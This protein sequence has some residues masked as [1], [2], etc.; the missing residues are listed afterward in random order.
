MKVLVVDMTHGG[1]VIASELS[2]MGFDVFAL[3]IY[4]TLKE[5]ARVSLVKKGVKMVQSSFLENLNERAVT[6]TD[7]DG[8]KGTC[9]ETY[10][11]SPESQEN[12]DLLL[13]LPVHCNFESEIKAAGNL[14]LKRMT[15]HEAVGFLLKNRINVP[16]IEV[17]GVKGKTSV[18]WMLKEI[19]KDLNPLVLSS[20]GVELIKDKKYQNDP[21]NGQIVE[22]E[23]Q[24]AIKTEETSG[25]SMKPSQK[26]D[27]ILKKNIS[28]TPAS[29]VEAFKLANDCETL[30]SCSMN[31]EVGIC[32]F[33]T[34]LGGT[35]LADVGVLTNVAENYPIAGGTRRASQAKAQIFKSK[36]VACNYKDFNSFYSK[37]GAS[38]NGDSVHSSHL[39]LDSDSVNLS[40]GLK[41]D[42][43]NS[44]YINLNKKTNTFG[45]EE[46]ANVR[47]SSIQFGLYRT[48][49]QLVVRNLK[50]IDGI[51]LNTSFEV[52]TFAPA[53][54]H[55]QNVL[56]VICASLTLGIPV[57]TIKQ[58]L[59]NFRGVE[60]RT[61]IGDREGS[62]VIA[63]VNPGLN[64][65][66]VKKAL[67]MVSNLERAGIVFGGKYGVTCEEIDEK[68]VS[69][70]LNDLNNSIPLV[71]V[72]E[73]G[74]NVKNNI[75]RDFKYLT[76]LKDAVDWAH[77]AGCKSILVVYRSNFSDLKLR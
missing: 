57:K 32:I 61:S 52:S 44:E 25:L 73:L 10:R 63:E 65:T 17:T 53:P 60:G 7:L 29:I 19:F 33:E 66:A 26:Q 12:Y 16:V 5:D 4:H 8:N 58:G 51:L 24:T 37:S 18:V 77:D 62:M 49:I 13:V 11:K 15:H 69:E 76:N 31:Q 21:E 48:T 36:M 30:Q 27:L 70:V 42:P 20:L 47:T 35:G 9:T 50:T 38:L 59:K 28:I 41:S 43:N 72:D 54:Y 55:V 71:L 14:K 46:D 40:P 39:K 56:A 6:E 1:T 34:S 75:K 45:F 68:S 67:S 64:V 23:N 3:D 74:N 22:M 2:K